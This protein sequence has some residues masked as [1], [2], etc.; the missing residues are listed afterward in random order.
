MVGNL[1]RP[2][3]LARAAATQGRV[4]ARPWRMVSGPCGAPRKHRGGTVGAVA[5]VASLVGVDAAR[6]Q[7]VAPMGAAAPAP[8]RPRDEQRRGAPPAGA[9][10]ITFCVQYKAPPGGCVAVCGDAPALGGWL[11]GGAAAMEPRPG[12]TWVATVRLPAGSRVQYKYVLLDAGGRP[13]RWQEGPNLSLAAPPAPGTLETL[14][15]WCQRLQL[16]RTPAAGGG[17][18]GG[19]GAP[20]VW[21]MGGGGGGGG[22]GADG[23][24][25]RT[26]ARSMGA[27][28]HAAPPPAPPQ[29][30]RPPPPLPELQAEL[31]AALLAALSAADG[32]PARR[33]GRRGA[34]RAA[35]APGAAGGDADGEAL[36][37][38]VSGLRSLQAAVLRAPGG[39]PPPG[40]S[41][42]D[43]RALRAAFGP[44]G[45]AAAAAS[46]PLGLF[47]D[48]PADGDDDGGAA[49]PP[50]GGRLSAAL[51]VGGY[52]AAPRRGGGRP[53]SGSESDGE[54]DAAREQ[55]GGG[56]ADPLV[57]ALLSDDCALCCEY[58]HDALSSG[59][60]LD[61]GSY[62]SAA[63]LD[64]GG[65]P[66]G[67]PS[68]SGEWG[69]SRPR[70]PEA[71]AEL[72]A[73]VLAGR[74][75]AA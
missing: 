56:G 51:A 28:E 72:R 54:G 71:L 2:G 29:R 31:E 27:P 1:V 9:A 70:S 45:A 35:S 67:S 44:A 25:G 30:A 22:G 43:V 75:G 21:E 64:G 7:S 5:A 14:D 20:G 49:P 26:L 42:A 62:D 19:G 37:A 73:R 38:A 61:S 24:D 57:D 63:S 60:S 23:A 46:D 3:G 6:A 69:A 39:G 59:S 13:T 8:T 41:A 65:S 52:A 68:S 11:P 53:A 50:A 74:R 36:A 33:H 10:D 47:P 48:A 58:L 4:P 12:D 16:R 66:D 34:A 18:A 15:S 40:G 32:D 17:G 55:C